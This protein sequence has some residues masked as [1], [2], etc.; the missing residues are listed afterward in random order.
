MKIKPKRPFIASR[1]SLFFT[2]SFVLL[3]C[4]LL[5]GSI[6]I[7]AQTKTISGKVTDATN[8]PLIGVS[9]KIQGTTTG[10]ITDIDGMYSLSAKSGDVIE[11]SFVGMKPQLVTVGTQTSINIVLE[12]DAQMLG[13]TIVIGYGT[14]KKRDLTGSIVSIKAEDI[15]NRPSANPLASLQ[16]KVAGVQVVNTG[17]A[18]QDPEIRIRGTNSING[19][20]PLYVVDGLFN[21]NINF[22]NSADIESMEIL[23]D[24]S[25][26]AIFGVRGANG[27]IIITTKR[28]KEGQTLVNINTSFGFKTVADKIKLTN[29]AQFKELY[30]EQRANQGASP[31]DYTK[32]T[33]DT[34]W[35][36]EIF[37]TGFITNNN[38]SITSSSEKNKFYMGVGY[39]SEEGSMKHE[40]FSKITFNLSSDYNITKDFKVG[41]Q[42][43]GAR[44]TP[45]NTDLSI[46]TSGLKSALYAS[47]IAPAFNEEYQLYTTL[48]SFQKNE[49]AN[50]LAY[51]ELQKN[52]NKVIDYRVSGNAYGDLNFLKHFN[53]RVMYSLDYRSY[54]GRI[55]TPKKTIYD[56][57]TEEEVVMGDGKTAVEQTKLNETKVQSDYLLTYNN[58]FGD[59]NLTATAGF[60][61]YYN[62]LSSLTAKR[63]EGNG[64]PIANNP[65]KWFVSMGDANASTTGSTQ[66]E[67]STVSFLVRGLY[68][69]QN[70]YLF[71]GSFRRDGSSGFF[72]T[73]NEW[74]NFYSVGAGWVITEEDFMKD[75]KFFDFLKL[76]ASWGTLG[77]QNMDRVYPAQPILLNTSN[78]VFGDNI[79]PGYEIAYIPNPD[80]KWEKVQ[81]WE[82]GLETYLLNNRLNFEGVYYKKN[83]KDLLAEI[84]GIA[85]TKP[86]LGNLGELENKGVELSLSWSDKIGSNWRYTIGGNLTTI[87]NKV[88]SLYQQGYKITDGTSGITPFAYTEAGYPIGYFY[89][90]KVDGVYQSQADIDNSPVNT[91]TTVLP[92]DL[93]FN[94]FDGDGR[95]TLDDRT[96]IGNPTPDFTYGFSVNVGYKNIDLA[97]DMMGVYGNEIYR[98]WN[99]FT[100]SQFNYLE[101][102]MGRWHGEGTSNTEPIMNPLRSINSKDYPSEYFIEDGSFFRIRNIQLGY[103]FGADMLKKVRMTS[104]RV[105]VNAQNPKT[106]KNNSGY[107]PEIGGTA[108][109]FGIDGNP[110]PMP[111]VYTF[112]LNLT[113]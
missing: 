55:Y 35:Q 4:F 74:Q 28:A 81:A 77:N 44:S 92:G 32:W 84:P 30:D 78:A 43:N 111:A 40:E 64:L 100:W 23:K 3:T 52:T 112:G 101:S 62:S 71:N 51:I 75:F 102:R 63:G 29:A 72:Y 19:Y 59:H 99:T 54:D 24:P 38:V 41:F 103:T 88:I 96:M 56:V 6:S 58:K 33:A 68:N 25:S 31:F 10:T 90:Y 20:K 104:L 39:T 9:V 73:G 107:T 67:R 34:D 17:I 70:K 46:Y 57:D 2:R 22:L 26:L 109:A 97:V 47:P 36:D 53:F 69:Y 18:G 82:A 105:Y 95:I 110:Y 14:A 98:T 108:T 87:K 37:Q 94:D 7:Y 91:L 65:D 5:A 15:A 11:F 42:I 48:P 13:E 83:T 80:L 86:G 50:P 16:G 85:G 12:E 1:A 89:G 93:K 106:W 21:D 79:I 49:V 60:T 61:T 27:V 45:L 8:E 113:F 66:W 76:K